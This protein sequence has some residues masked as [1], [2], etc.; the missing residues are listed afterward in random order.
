MQKTYTLDGHEY[1][2][3]ELKFIQLREIVELLLPLQEHFGLLKTKDGDE[4]ETVDIAAITKLFGDNFL[5]AVACVLIRKGET[6]RDRNIENTVADLEV[7]TLTA[8]ENIILDF[9]SLNDLRSHFGRITG[10]METITIGKTGGKAEPQQ[11]STG[12]KSSTKSAT[13]TLEE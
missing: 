5:Q 12:K 8:I 4:T 3:E 9:F 13:A 1:F 11:T 7:E 6:V 2:Q 10:I